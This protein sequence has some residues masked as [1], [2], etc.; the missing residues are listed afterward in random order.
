MIRTVVTP[1]QQNI[2]I[3]V[4]ES[5]VGKKVEVI[6]FT[7]DEVEQEALTT[8]KPLT[9]LASEK[10]LAKDWLSNEEDQAWQHL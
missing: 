2:S 7:T 5:F 6:V 4:P 10:L 8:D 3:Q 9:H 1:E